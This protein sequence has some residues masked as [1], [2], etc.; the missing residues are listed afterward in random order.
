MRDFQNATQPDDE[1]VVKE[2]RKEK[3]QES[4]DTLFGK[5]GVLAAAP[6][7]CFFFFAVFEDDAGVPFS[8]IFSL[9]SVC[10][11]RVCANEQEQVQKT[12]EEEKAAEEGIFWFFGF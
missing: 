9:W 5:E 8:P 11:A 3:K 1:R 12:L 6:D 2:K 7:D 4:R 10:V